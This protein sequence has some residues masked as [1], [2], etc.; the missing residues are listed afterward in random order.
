MEWGIFRR[1]TEIIEVGDLFRK[2]DDNLGRVWEVTRLWVTVDGLLHARL[3]VL[4]D[5]GE[6]IIVST[7]ALADNGHFRSVLPSL[8]E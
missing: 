1:K 3:V 8:D 6:S 5:S 4:G 2:V 7:M